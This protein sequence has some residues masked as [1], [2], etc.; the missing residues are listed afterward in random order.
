MN[1]TRI[2]VGCGTTPI[3]GWTNFDNSWTV[4]FARYPQ[5]ERVLQI[6]SPPRA[7]FAEIVREQT[8]CWADAVRRIPVPERSA[9]ALYSAHMLE[10]LDRQEAHS[11]LREAHRVLAPGAILRITVPDLS[12][13]ARQ[14]VRDGDA[15][16]FVGAT[17]LAVRKPRSLAQRVKHVVVGSRH[18]HWMYDGKSLMKLVADH[19]FHDVQVLSPGATMIPDPGNLNL[20]ERLE[21]SVFVEGRRT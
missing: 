20:F 18:H 9:R 1:L 5:A 19:G 17:L 6:F 8:I 2:N 21:Q 13:L 16:A 12:L 7:R 15:D 11:F 3:P 14:Y 4:R 10:H